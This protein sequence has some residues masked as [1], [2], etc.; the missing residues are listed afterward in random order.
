MLVDRQGRPTTDPNTLFAEPKQSALLP[1]GEHKGSGLALFCE[2]LAGVA[3]GGGTIQPGNGWHDGVINSMLSVI[4]DPARLGER[5]AM[6]AELDALIDFV[7][8]CAPT[9]PDKPVLVAG[10]PER[11]K[12]AE[13]RRNGID[14]DPT[15]WEQLLEAAETVGVGREQAIAT[16]G[17]AF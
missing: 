7:K 3:G 12:S 9:D 5:G 6:Q 17:I 10:E 15:T 16:V 1:F 8:S 14:I 4:I 11:L 2:L 13:R